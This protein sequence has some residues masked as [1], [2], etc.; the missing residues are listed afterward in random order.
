M[1]QSLINALAHIPLPIATAL[2]ALIPSVELSVALPVAVL[3]FGLPIWVAYVSSVAG[4]FLAVVIVFLGAE[5]VTRI[6]H[7]HV[8]F[9]RRAIDW[10]FAHTRNKFT[11]KYQRYGV[12]ALLLFTATPLPV[13]FSGAWSGALAAWLLGI[14]AHRAVPWL[15][16]GILIAG[17]IMVMLLVSGSALLSWYLPRA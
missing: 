10:V 1:V 12:A 16:L 15:A 11:A 8:P 9:T 4:S 2:I 17:G 7:A 13:P 3:R 5:P 6:L 14:P